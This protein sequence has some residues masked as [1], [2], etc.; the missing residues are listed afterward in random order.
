MNQGK[1]IIQKVK[2]IY[3]DGKIDELDGITVEY[4]DWWF[5]LRPSNTEPILRLVVEAETQ[6]IMDQKVKEISELI[7]RF[8]V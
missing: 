6:Y 7:S 8:S 2:E 3:K 1:D 5:N 4:K